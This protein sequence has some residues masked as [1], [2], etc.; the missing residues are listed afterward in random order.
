MAYC[1]VF[2]KR[3][4]DPCPPPLHYIY[5]QPSTMRCSSPEEMARADCHGGHGQGRN[6]KGVQDWTMPYRPLEL[7][8]EK[9]TVRNLSRFYQNKLF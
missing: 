4:S 3:A 5:K 6:Q 8:T 2:C 9:S 1:V 7:C